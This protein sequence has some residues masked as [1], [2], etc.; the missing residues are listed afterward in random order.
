MEKL[1]FNVPDMW[2]DHHVLKVRAVLDAIEGVQDV[3]A[4]SAF[5]MVV[6]S[7]DPDLTSPGA[8]WAA[9]EDAGYSVSTDGA[10]VI[11]EAVPVASGKRDPAWARLGARQT[12]TDERDLKT[13]R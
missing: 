6:L 11:A 8:I 1:Q 13:K 9:L 5:R 10:G 3:I 12:R 4:S 7:Y 2:A